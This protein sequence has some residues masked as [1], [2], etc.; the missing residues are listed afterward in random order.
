MKNR[1]ESYYLVRILLVINS[2]PTGTEPAIIIR[3][4][5]R[6]IVISL[7]KETTNI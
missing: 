4:I 5:E 1:D 7:T 2:I 3:K 6:Y